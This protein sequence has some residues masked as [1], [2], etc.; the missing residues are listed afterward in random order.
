ML[1]VAIALLMSLAACFSKP[2]RPDDGAGDGPQPTDGPTA[3]GWLDGYQ[4]RKHVT[5]TSGLTGTL[6]NFPVGVSVTDS[7]IAQ[8][9]D[10][11]GRD[12]V[13]TG[14]DGTTLLASELAAYSAGALEIW[15][16]LPE[17]GP[18]GA[19]YLY[20]K[21]DQQVPSTSVW[22]GS[23]FAGVWHLSEVGGTARDSTAQANHMIASS[24]DIPAS[25]ADGV[26]GPARS[27]DGNDS[28]S[29]GDPGDGS[30]DF[31]SGSFS[32]S[33]WVHQNQLL[34]GGFDTPFYKGGTSN[35]EPGYCWLLG[36]ANWTGKITD[37]AAHVADPE[38]GLAATFQNR[39]VHIAAVIDRAADA[40]SVYADGVLEDSQSLSGNL[41]GSVSTIEPLQLGRPADDPFVGR[42]DEIRI[43]KTAVTQEWLA[44][45]VRNATEPGF[46]TFGPVEAK[47]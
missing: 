6:A 32:Y 9:A 21:G 24:T 35:S 10:N 22:D 31:G 40:M 38:L 25:F 46:L 8:E 17:L 3:E 42:I 12:I 43:Y 15:V 18:T 29:G 26:F 39:W 19:F 34:G 27:L 2:P 13:A 5:V 33:L 4:F 1:R 47:P 11:S 23:D 36:T 44:T 30:I 20:Y 37:T 28:M 7:D 45:E 41:I 16:R 14:P